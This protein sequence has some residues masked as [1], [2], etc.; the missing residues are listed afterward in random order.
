[1]V[2]PHFT[3]WVNPLFIG[4]AVWHGLVMLSCVT[5]LAIPFYK[6]PSSR[7][8]HSW[9]ISGHYPL[10]SSGIP[11]IVPNRCMV[12]ALCE[13]FSNVMYLFLAGVCYLWR[14][15]TD[16]PFFSQYL[17]LWYAIG[18]LFSYLGIW[19]AGWGLCYA[20]LCDV[21]RARRQKFARVLTPIVYNTA[22]MS[23]SIVTIALMGFLASS[24]CRSGNSLRESS[25]RL[26]SLLNEASAAWEDTKDIAE[27]PLSVL[28]SQRTVILQGVNLLTWKYRQWCLVWIG[29]DVVLAIFYSFTAVYLL[30]MTRSLLVRRDIEKLACPGDL[31]SLI[32]DELKHEF[33]FLSRSCGIISTALGCE[34]GVAVY[35]FYYG[36]HLHSM[37]WTTASVLIVHI[38]GL[39]ISPS[40]LFQSW[41]IFTERNAADDTSFHE[42]AMDTK[43]PHLPELA[44]QLLGW[45]ST[46]HWGHLQ[47]DNDQ[48]FP[49]VCE[50]VQ[51]STA[52]G[53][54]QHMGET[55]QHK[56]SAQINIDITRSVV[57]TEENLGFTCSSDAKH[58][59]TIVLPSSKPNKPSGTFKNPKSRSSTAESI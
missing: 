32:W 54:H 3:T 21:Q 38:P 39:V 6:G 26:I 11:Y 31:P 34:I 27:H 36:S 37:K 7:K 50:L 48:N 20:C 30:R 18:W 51:Q 8:Q 24:M 40:L 19:L 59:L 58:P 1:M 42:A 10:Q 41:R 12:I 9:M 25:Q 56:G 29:L 44:S 52:N 55:A 35:Q 43:I 2:R 22:W 47:L 45:Q 53:H 17:T 23:W 5:I 15:T 28:I 14:S 57:T 33:R 16:S 13:F 49:G 46:I 4:L